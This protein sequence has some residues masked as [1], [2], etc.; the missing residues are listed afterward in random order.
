MPRRIKKTANTEKEKGT[1]KLAIIGIRKRKKRDLTLK[2]LYR[3][4][5]NSKIPKIPVV[6]RS[7][8]IKL[9]DL[10]K[11]KDQRAWFWLKA[12]CLNLVKSVMYVQKQ[13]PNKNP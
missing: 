13:E 11:V 4:N 2:I 10:K 3:R 6:A 12:G 5:I 1:S 8:K 9:D 7:S